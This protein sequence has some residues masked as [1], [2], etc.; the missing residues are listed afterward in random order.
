MQG[1]RVIT[2]LAA[3]IGICAN[4]N[5][6]KYHS[7][8]TTLTFCNI[9]ISIPPQINALRQKIV[10]IFLS[11]FELASIFYPINF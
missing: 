4:D 6:I 11:M 5:I 2:D 8:S 3:V 7:L 10:Q 1:G 9:V